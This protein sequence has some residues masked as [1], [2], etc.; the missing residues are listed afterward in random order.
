MSEI[1]LEIDYREKSIIKLIEDTVNFP[2][3]YNVCNLII[4]DIVIK[5]NDDIL[6]ILER[7]TI[8]DLAASIT[9]GRFREQKQRLYESVNGCYDKIIYI[10][11]GVKTVKKYCSISKTTINSSII[12]LIFKH[13][14]KVIHTTDEKD[15][16]DSILNICSKLHKNEFDK[17]IKTNIKII[18]KG[19]N[20]NPF[21]NILCTIPGVSSICA[22]KIKETY[23]SLSNLFDV[24]KELQDIN[25]KYDLLAELQI[26]KRKIGKVLSK[27]IYCYLFNELDKNKEQECLL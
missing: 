3:K 17:P 25:Q 22:T 26:N 27:K 7:K 12:N 11:E 8:L 5:E 21:I 14:Y 23:I 10:I 16:I 6:Y 20:T 2:V 18:K 1:T 19:E 13:K 9:D 4:G 24:Y 15:T